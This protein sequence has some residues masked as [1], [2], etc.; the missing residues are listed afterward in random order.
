MFGH[1]RTETADTN[2]ISD[3]LGDSLVKDDPIN[4]SKAD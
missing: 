3:L 2:T 4:D 1:L